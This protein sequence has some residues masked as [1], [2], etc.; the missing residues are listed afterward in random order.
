MTYANALN[1]V[2]LAANL[3]GVI[4]LFR[5]GMPFRVPT[6]G[7]S[8]YTTETP[9]PKVLAAE[10]VYWWLGLLGLGLIVLGTL[11]QIVA[12]FLP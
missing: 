5:Y 11:A 10:R 6:G 12:V 9:D 2:G 3:S 7:Y 4:L 8:F 1:V